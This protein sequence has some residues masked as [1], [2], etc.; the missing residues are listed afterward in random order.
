VRVSE[1]QEMHTGEDM[2]LIDEPPAEQEREQVAAAQEEIAAL[3]GE[4][5]QVVVEMRAEHSG[6]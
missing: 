5:N 1:V 3:A 4:A 6:Q 2:L